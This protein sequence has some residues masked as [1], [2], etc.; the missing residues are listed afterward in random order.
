MNLNILEDKLVK[1][2][3]KLFSEKHADFWDWDLIGRLELEIKELE[4]EILKG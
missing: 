2:K 1:L 3:E 4:L